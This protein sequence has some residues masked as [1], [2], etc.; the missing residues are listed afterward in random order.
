MGQLKPPFGMERFTSDAVIKTIDR[1][2]TTDLLVPNGKLGK[3][4][5]RDLG[6]QIDGWVAS[7]RRYYAFGLFEGKGANYPINKPSMMATVRL[8]YKKF[9]DRTLGGWKMSGH[10]G[11]PFRFCTPIGL[12]LVGAVQAGNMSL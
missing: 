8:V 5:T 1:A 11:A 7:D 10:V 9:D 6:L 2:Q 12:I 3:S 4:F